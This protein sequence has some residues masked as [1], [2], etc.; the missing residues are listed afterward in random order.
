M[1]KFN[2]EELSSWWNNQTSKIRKE[3]LK[4]ARFH[5]ADIKGYKL[6]NQ[7]I[8]DLE[9]SGWGIESI[10]NARLRLGI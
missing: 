10:S 6:Y 4:E 1:S 5:S 3:I 2:K 8:W 9:S 7:S